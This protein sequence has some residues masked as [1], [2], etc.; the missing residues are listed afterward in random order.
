MKNGQKCQK[1]EKNNFFEIKIDLQLRFG[2]KKDSY[3]L[4]KWRLNGWNF[5][6]A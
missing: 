6:L 2:I 1:V 3:Y 5:E 4:K